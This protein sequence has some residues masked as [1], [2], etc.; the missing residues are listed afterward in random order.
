MGGTGSPRFSRGAA[1]RAPVED[2]DRQGDGVGEP[3]PRDS[4]PDFLGHPDSDQ[5]TP[6]AQV[7]TAPE[8]SDG[9]ELARAMKA[10]E[11]GDLPGNGLGYWSEHSWRGERVSVLDATV[12]EA[13]GREI[14]AR[15]RPRDYSLLFAQLIAAKLNTGDAAHVAAIADAEAWLLRRGLTIADWRGH[16][17]SQEERSLALGFAQALAALNNQ[18]AHDGGRTP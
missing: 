6:V 2:T 13:S 5:T 11:R 4:E 17:E 12:D 3:E 14:I 8:L 1:P 9:A 10:D 7:L 16:F 18:Y 15:A